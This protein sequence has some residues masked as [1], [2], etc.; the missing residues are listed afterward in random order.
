MLEIMGGRLKGFSLRVPRG[1][2][3]T[4]AT[5]RRSLFDRLGRYVEGRSLLELYAGSGAVGIEALSRG[6]SRVVFVER[7]RGGFRVLLSNLRRAELP[8][9][10]AFVVR[11][12]V[13][14]AVR[15]LV[16]RGERFHWCFA[17]PP[18]AGD[19]QMEAV[20]GEL[21]RLVTEMVVLEASSRSPAPKIRGFS[22]EREVVLGDAKLGFYLPGDL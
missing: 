6:A 10:R 20:L 13:L 2:R 5:V 8:K 9:E 7:S 12:S 16:Q 22:L 1:I 18:Y 21:H 3:P 4:S 11:K 14:A 19:D 17:D 15:E